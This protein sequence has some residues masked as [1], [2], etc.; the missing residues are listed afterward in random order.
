MIWPA[1]FQVSCISKRSAAAV[2][3]VCRRVDVSE[4][5]P[6]RG[7]GRMSG[8]YLNCRRMAPV[9]QSTLKFSSI[10]ERDTLVCNKIAIIYDSAALSRVL[11]V[12]AEMGQGNPA[13]RIATFVDD[14]YEVS[15]SFLICGYVFRRLLNDQYCAARWS[16][17]MIRTSFWSD[18]T[19][20]CLG[21]LQSDSSTHRTMDQASASV[22]G[23]ASRVRPS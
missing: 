7:A 20:T 4:V 13:G 9:R 10:S 21:F 6:S 15:W 5:D 18:R 22:P 16:S 17:M 1:A 3:E 8:I 23:E 12:G 2:A 11:N 19:W 14:Q